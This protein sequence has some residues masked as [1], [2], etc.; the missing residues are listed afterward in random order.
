MQDP[1]PSVAKLAVT[2]ILVRTSKHSVD[3]STW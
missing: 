3:L 2:N 1:A